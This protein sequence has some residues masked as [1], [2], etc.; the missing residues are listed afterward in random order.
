MA[1]RIAAG[2]Q[3]DLIYVDGSHTLGD[4]LTDLLLADRLLIPGG[5]LL[6]DDIDN[7]DY[8]GVRAAWELMSGYERQGRPN[9]GV[10]RNE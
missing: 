7:A 8:P 3:F 1:E 10:G 5:W 9:W 6:C 4:A 2:R